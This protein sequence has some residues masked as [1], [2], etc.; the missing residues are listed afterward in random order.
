M[1]F[2]K[3]CNTLGLSVS[4]LNSK[5]IKR[6]YFKL[7]LIW[8]PDKNPTDEALHKFQDIKN[9]YEF[10]MYEEDHFEHDYSAIISNL[11]THIT[12]LNMT[13][14]ELLTILLD[15]RNE[16]TDN[17]KQV[18]H[19]IEYVKCIKL[20]NFIINHASI[21]GLDVQLL[22]RIKQERI[23]NGIIV[24]PTI[25]NIMNRDIFKLDLGDTETY[26]IPLWHD[27]LDYNNELVV[28]IRPLLPPHIQMDDDNNIHYYHNINNDEHDIGDTIYVYIANHQFELPYSFLSTFCFPK[29]GIPKINTEDIFSIMCISDV[30]I[31]I[32]CI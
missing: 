24:E 16:Y 19:S 26:Y 29:R 2:H 5:T 18:F 17:L 11:L 9:A 7:A 8:H 3:A 22:T 14:D 30:I 6:A 25:D 28:K 13:Y 23:N 4:Q 32:T 20:L 12:G 21:F 31:H 1:D 10:L 15:I 27:E